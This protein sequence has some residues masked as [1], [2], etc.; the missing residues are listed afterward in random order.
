MTEAAAMGA[1]KKI[2]K[3]AGSF[4]MRWVTVWG[5]PVPGDWQTS[6]LF[7]LD[8]AGYEARTQGHY[9]Q[10]RWD[11]DDASRVDD[12]RDFIRDYAANAWGKPASAAE[13]VPYLALAEIAMQRAEAE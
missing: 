9:V 5:A 10:V 2:A 11:A 1:T 12:V 13:M 6:V 7:A 3:P 8:L 4:N